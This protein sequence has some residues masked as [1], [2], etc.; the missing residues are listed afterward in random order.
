MSS[1]NN[2]IQKE[3]IT[4]KV[5]WYAFLIDMVVVSYKRC[6]PFENKFCKLKFY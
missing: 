6:S 4:L 1:C 2:S 5:M 3:V